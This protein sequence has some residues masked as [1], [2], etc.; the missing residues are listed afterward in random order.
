MIASMCSAALAACAG[1]D[2]VG[3]D[4]QFAVACGDGPTVNGIDVSYYEASVDWAAVHAAGI[5]FAFAR[6]SDGLDF[7]DPTFPSYWAGA[8]AAG[9]I[10]GAYQFFRPAEDPIAQ[11]DLVLDAIGTLG[12]GDLPPVIDVEVSG[13]LSPAQVAAAVRAWVDHVTARLGRAPIIYAGLYSWHDLTGS[14]DLTS[15]PLWVAQYTS[16]ACPNIPTPWTRWM[17]WQTSSSGS[18]PGIPGAALDLDV[19]NGSLDQLRAFA[20]PGVC[21][22]AICSGGETPERCPIDC[23]P[24]G[25][26]ARTGGEIDDG[27]AC[28]VA[29]GPAQYLRRVAGAGDA[30]D[31]IW[32]HTTASAA[33]ANFAQWN[34]YF[35]AA[36]R[37]RVEVYTAHSYAGSTRAAYAIRASGGA[38]AVLVDQ[39]A[40]DG[41][42]SLGEIGF[43]AGG[44][45]SIHLGDN[46]GEPGADNVQLV[47][48][49]VRLTRVADSAP[50]TDPDPTPAD[51]MAPAIAADSGGCAAAPSAG[52]PLA[53]CVLAL[54]LC[55]RRRAPPRSAAQ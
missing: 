41:W 14:A 44:D 29:G 38:T 8:K 10:R 24:C 34:L 40:V 53:L 55:R 21:G 49:A 31:L 37:Y 20:A 2:Q 9:M 19:F 39:T 47:F 45:Q 17:F 16:A 35:E 28:F 51:P 3:T 6:V 50:G 46:T 15:S 27:D 11:A 18:V 5:E 26:I 23:A 36:G 7:I 43:A 42:Q 30:G 4:E 54:G 33:E 48:D 1:L 32:T 22:D 12:P 13:D 25:T 52:G